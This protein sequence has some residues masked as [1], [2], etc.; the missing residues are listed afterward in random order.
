MAYKISAEKCVACGSCASECPQNAINPGTPYRIDAE[1]C[2][3][4]G[5]CETGCPEQAIASG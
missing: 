4:C 2:I 5:A 3:D 1:K